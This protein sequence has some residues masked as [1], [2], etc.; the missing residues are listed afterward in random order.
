MSQDESQQLATQNANNNL[1][2][3][4][5]IPFKFGNARNSINKTELEELK[6]S[7]TKLGVIQPITVRAVENGNFEV[8]AGNRRWLAS[9]ELNLES[10]P[11]NIV[12][13]NDKDAYEAHLAENLSRKNLSIVDEAKAAKHFISIS[14]GDYSEA[15]SRLGWSEK[16]VNDRLQL[17]RC[18]EEVL[19]A[20]ENN[21][22]KIAH[23]TLLSAFSHKLQQGTLEKIINEKWSVQYL[24]ERASK[25]KKWLHKAP[26]NTSDCDHCH[27]NTIHQNDLFDTGINQKAQCAN[28]ACYKT[29]KDE[30]LTIEKN[31]AQERFGKVLLWLEISDKNTNTVASSI[32]G[33]NQFTTGCTGC[34]NLAV[35][36][37]DR[38]GHEGKLTQSQCLDETCFKKCCIAYQKSIEPI[39]ETINSSTATTSQVTK[40][41]QSSQP[42]TTAQ[43]TPK[44]VTIKEK[45]TLRTAAFDTLK[46]NPQLIN[47]LLV[48][49]VAELTTCKNDIMKDCQHF[50]LKN[51]LAFQATPQEINHVISNSLLDFL[52]NQKDEETLQAKSPTNILITLLK[53]Q[54]H[55]KAIMAWT[56]DKETLTNYTINGIIELCKQSGFNKAFNE[57]KTNIDKK[58]SF[59]QIS[60]LGKA[61]FIEKITNF[62]PFSWTNFAPQS[63][64]KHFKK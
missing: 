20:L 56:A 41:P 35:I 42:S 3:T 19:N 45:Q 28:L 11:A 29:K 50:N 26:F 55:S 40:K 39:K 5:L 37:D 46:D 1:P 61:K 32:V 33:E 21:E 51:A 43:S 27:H 36:I 9:Q 17:L 8:I 7:I 49:L 48:T 47:A 4:N 12:L 63:Y 60:K 44:N 53:D 59:E 34:A 18:C 6:A 30:F 62:T 16:K 13:M 15:A 64:L 31:N 2:L 14:Q 57:D 22:I 38:D 52:S 54:D 23:A 24:T 10:I 58:T 25:A